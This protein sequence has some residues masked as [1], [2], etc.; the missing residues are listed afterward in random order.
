MQRV[1][2]L[3]LI[4]LFLLACISWIPAPY[5]L[6]RECFTAVGFQMKS[7]SPSP[8]PA[9]A[10]AEDAVQEAADD[11]VQFNMAALDKQLLKKNK[12]K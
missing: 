10:A 3:F 8:A 5:R 4:Y 2:I 12:K 7:I 9:A 11:L 1:V 6:T